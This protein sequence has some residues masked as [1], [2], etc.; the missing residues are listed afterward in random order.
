MAIPSARPV[1]CVT[2]TQQTRADSAG[3]LSRRRFIALAGGGVVLATPLAGCSGVYPSSTV[4][5]WQPVPESTEIRRYMLA[6]ALLAPNP[7]NR[8]PWL[9][10]LKRESEITLV[11][12]AERLLPH[13]DP[14]GRQILV[15]CGAF[16]EL[17]VMAAAQRGFGVQVELFPAGEPGLRELPGGKVVARLVLSRDPA[18]QRDPLF[19]QIQKRHTNKTAY[20]NARTLPAAVLQ[21]LQMASAVTDQPRGAVTDASRMAQIRKLTRESY[22]IETVTPRTYLESAELLRIGSSEIE[23]HRDGISITGLMPTV[24]SSVGL[25][26]RFEVPSVG[27]SNYQRLMDRWAPFETGSGYVWIAARDTG[28]AQQVAAGR[29]WVRMHLQATALGLDMHPLSQALQEFVE[30]K[31]QYEAMHRLLGLD[32]LVTPL[33]MLARVGYAAAPVEGSPRRELGGIVQV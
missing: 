1:P 22:E 32:P 12:D 15:G 10:D 20:D 14:F 19:A 23:K 31:P 26:N 17:A 29:A 25:F 21:A 3:A 9:A 5:A 13:T 8:Q 11:C 6:H 7:H 30:V 24:L 16:I 18:V 2:A 4:Q 28:R 27:S 33:Q